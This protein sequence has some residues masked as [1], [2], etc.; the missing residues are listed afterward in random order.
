MVTVLAR[1][2]RERE[3]VNRD[4]HYSPHFQVGARRSP[5]GPSTFSLRQLQRHAVRGTLLHGR[6]HPRG[7]RGQP[8]PGGSSEGGALVA[9][10][11]LQLIAGFGGPGQ[12]VVA[13]ALATTTSF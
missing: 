13:S 9:D 6:R 1:G 2:G 8:T 7:V 5:P 11:G 4:D 10:S 12:P 3:V